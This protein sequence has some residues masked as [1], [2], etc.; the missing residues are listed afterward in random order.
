MTGSVDHTAR[1]WDL[2]KSPATSQELRGHTDFIEAIAFSPDGRFA[3]TGSDDTTARLWD[4]SKS[5]IT[6]QE[7]KGHTAYV[8][9]IAFSP[10]G[11][12][13]LLGLMDNN[14]SLWQ[15]EYVDKTLSLL[16]HLLILKLTKSEDLVMHDS[17]ALNCLKAV[18]KKPDLNPQAAKLI[19]ALFYRMDL[20]QRN[21]SICKQSYDPEK[22]KCMQMVCCK[23]LICKCCLNENTTTSNSNEFNEYGVVPFVEHCIMQSPKTRCPLC[24]THADQL[25]IAKIFESKKKQG[26]EC[27]KIL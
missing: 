1:L 8:L 19:E 12:F 22:R 15:I 9:S 23:D 10:D 5:P 16:D 11:Q 6:C 4:L 20:P 21:C 14:A 18:L 2:T 25:D 13:A 3:L 27:I 17:E 24:H 26:K 7:L